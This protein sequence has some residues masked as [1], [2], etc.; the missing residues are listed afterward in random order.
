MI[1]NESDFYKKPDMRPD[2]L[3]DFLDSKVSRLL[4]QLEEVPE[5]SHVEDEGSA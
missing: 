5:N 3:P 2:L 4:Y 1:E